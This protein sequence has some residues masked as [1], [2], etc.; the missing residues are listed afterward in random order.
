MQVYSAFQEHADIPAGADAVPQCVRGKLT[1]GSSADTLALGKKPTKPLRTEVQSLT[2]KFVISGN[3]NPQENS[4]H[5]D[6]DNRIR[7]SRVVSF[8]AELPRGLA[9][10]T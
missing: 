6:S 2:R 7:L 9:G 1:E 5:S 10:H 8:F 3:I 4:E